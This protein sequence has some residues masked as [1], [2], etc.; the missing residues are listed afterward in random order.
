MTS[1]EYS[2]TLMPEY[3]QHILEN[4]SG[5]KPKSIYHLMENYGTWESQ[6]A[7]MELERLCK[8]GKAKFTHNMGPNFQNKFFI[9]GEN[10]GKNIR[11]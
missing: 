2:K 11:D 9:K 10:Y 5:K 3:T 7:C 1:E 4:L 6:P 8:I